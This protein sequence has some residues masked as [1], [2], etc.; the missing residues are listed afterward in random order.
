MAGAFLLPLLASFLAAQGGALDQAELLGDT[1]AKGEITREQV[2]ARLANCGIRRFETTAE[3]MIDGRMRRTTIRLCAADNESNAEWLA[4]LETSASQVEAQT[5]LPAEVKTKLLAELRAEIDRLRG[6]RPAQ[7]SRPATTPGPSATT[8][9]VAEPAA[10]VG[11][12][13]GAQEV[14]VGSDEPNGAASEGLAEP[15]PVETVPTVV[16]PPPATP[17]PAAVATAGS[18]GTPRIGI[19]CRGPDDPNGGVECDRLTTDTALL[20]T[21]LSDLPKGSVLRFSR[22]S[23]RPQADV[24]LASGLRKG[25]STRVMVPKAICARVFRTSFEVAVVTPGAAAASAID[26][27]GPYETRC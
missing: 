8:E 9:A 7:A 19:K 3:G 14:A 1:V 23:G 16:A 18:I 24:R 6:L 20:V 26:R 25:Q 4:K 22:E 17:S 10:P 15:P 27:H 11:Q 21:A 5:R 12:P 2:D 13:D